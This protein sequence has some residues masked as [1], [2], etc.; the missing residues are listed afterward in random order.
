MS[1]LTQHLYAAPQG[2]PCKTPGVVR[3]YNSGAETVANLT[4]T[5]AV[6]R[7]PG[8]RLRE[9]TRC[10]SIEIDVI[11]P[12]DS[13]DPTHLAKVLSDT[14]L[15]V[16]KQVVRG[17]LRLGSRGNEDFRI[18]GR[19]IVHS[20]GDDEAP[21]H[22]ITVTAV[23][24]GAFKAKKEWPTVSEFFGAIGKG[25]S[26]PNPEIRVFG[27]HT[28]P[29]ELWKGMKLPVSL[30]PNADGEQVE[31]E[32]TGVEVSFKTDNGTETVLVSGKRDEFIVAT[33]FF[34]SSNVGPDLFEL[35]LNHSSELATKLFRQP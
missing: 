27:I 29:R 26:D 10:G 6:P 24:T 5:V 17:P 21:H 19:Y 13:F 14:E 28:Y 3:G 8:G 30:G 2:L 15:G 7:K 25:V 18:A 35:A 1:T 23:S 9:A 20:S 33:I 12:E 11:V 34:L 16:P 4:E 22:H 32:L 31:A